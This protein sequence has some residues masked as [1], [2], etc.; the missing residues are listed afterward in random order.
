M[1]K[2]RG[3]S[4]ERSIFKIKFNVETERAERRPTDAFVEGDQVVK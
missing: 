2:N 1:K 4:V 3:A